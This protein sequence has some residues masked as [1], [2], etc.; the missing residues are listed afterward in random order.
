MRMTNPSNHGFGTNGGMQNAAYGNISRP[1]WQQAAWRATPTTETRTRGE[2]TPAPKIAETESNVVGFSR[3]SPPKQTLR[4]VAFDAK[5][6]R[7]KALAAS[8]VSRRV[9]TMDGDGR[10]RSESEGSKSDIAATLGNVGSQDDIDLALQVL[11]RHISWAEKRATTLRNEAGELANFLKEYEERATIA[12]AE[13]SDLRAEYLR[14]KASLS[15]AALAVSSAPPATVEEAS[16]EPMASTQEHASRELP[17]TRLGASGPSLVETPAD[18]QKVSAKAS[19][20]ATVK[21][22]AEMQEEAPVSEEAQV[23]AEAVVQAEVTT[24]V[25]GMAQAAD[26]QSGITAPGQIVAAEGPTASVASLTDFSVAGEKGSKGAWA[27]RAP[28][29]VVIELLGGVLD[30]DDTLQAPGHRGFAMLPGVAKA[31]REMREDPRLGDARVAIMV[32]SPPPDW[33][34]T[35]L[36]SCQ[37]VDGTS[38]FDFADIIAAS[39]PP[40]S[41]FSY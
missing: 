24:D 17:Q 21:G 40:P 3:F 22:E 13:L 25:G 15:A 23:E 41:P 19:V 4:E 14:L 9:E 16:S 33:V 1:K 37:V 35:A 38:L 18:P 6:E 12:E 2:A 20:E 30:T 7:Q 28:Q 34:E 31:L 36:H 10:N 32:P 8:F 39:P 27:R 26:G 11:D 29:L 5:L